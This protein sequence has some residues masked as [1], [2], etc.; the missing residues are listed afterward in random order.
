MAKF[1]L[2]GGEFEEDFTE[3]Q[4]RC[5]NKVAI[6]TNKMLDRLKNEAGVEYDGT[7]PLFLP[8]EAVTP[9]EINVHNS[10]TLKLQ[11]ALPDLLEALSEEE[12]DALLSARHVAQ[13][14]VV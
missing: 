9:Y 12:Q 10:V 7:F 14:E 4:V 8:F 1:K 5:F 2:F 6:E 3:E 11:M 13:L